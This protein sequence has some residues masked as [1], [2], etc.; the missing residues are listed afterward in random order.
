MK[1]IR[2]TA[3]TLPLIQNSK[4]KIQSSKFKGQAALIVALAAFVLITIVGLAVD[5][6]SMY[7]QRRVSQ[8][9]AD[10]S[11]MAGTRQ[12][13]VYYE[14]MANNTVVDDDFYPTAAD[15]QA[16][17]DAVRQKIEDY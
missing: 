3:H 14:D 17:E 5:G 1:K 16:R 12:M 9:G 6:G 13:L 4:F 11:T 8:N 15:A 2:D 10:G 7:N